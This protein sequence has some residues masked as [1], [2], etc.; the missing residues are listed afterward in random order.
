[1]ATDIDKDIDTDI[2]TEIATDKATDTVTDIVTD[3]AMDIATDIAT[4]KATDTATDIASGIITDIATVI[5][6]SRH[7][8]VLV[9]AIYRITITTQGKY[10]A[11]Q[12]G[13]LPYLVALLADTSSEVRLNALKVW[14]RTSYY[15]HAK[16]VFSGVIMCT[17]MI[18]DCDWSV[19]VQLFPNR[20]ANICNSTVQKS[21]PTVQKS[22][23]TVQESVQQCKNL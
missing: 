22:V 18:L 11:I 10:S 3:T 2:V 7:F 15:F 16:F 12:N 17:E 9:F 20:S 21:V 1:M 5:A 4:D 8:D 14:E 13:V 19:S 6:T 23:P